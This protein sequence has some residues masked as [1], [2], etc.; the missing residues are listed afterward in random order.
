MKSKTATVTNLIRVFPFFAGTIQQDRIQKDMLAM[1]DFRLL[2][3][4]TPH[5]KRWRWSGTSAGIDVSCAIEVCFESHRIWLPNAREEWYWSPRNWCWF[6]SLVNALSIAGTYNAPQ[7]ADDMILRKFR[8]YF[9]ISATCV[10]ASLY[11]FAFLMSRVILMC[12]RVEKHIDGEK[13]EN[14]GFFLCHP[15]QQSHLAKHCWCRHRYSPF[16]QSLCSKTFLFWL[17]PRSRC[18][19]EIFVV[20]TLHFIRWQQTSHAARPLCRRLRLVAVDNRKAFRKLLY[21]ST[22]KW[23]KTSREDSGDDKHVRE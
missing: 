6:L 21:R 10:C 5:N 14:K 22:E 13:N 3:A 1:R 7:Y 16:L 2:T 11:Q 4:S 9:I 18:I 8:P 23:K 20:N 17:E 12:S 19:G 15:H